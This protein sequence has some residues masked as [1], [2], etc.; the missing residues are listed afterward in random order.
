MEQ[1]FALLT[2][3]LQQQL[4]NIEQK[5]DTKTMSQLKS[6]QQKFLELE[7]SHNI[8]R[9]DYEA[10][11]RNCSATYIEMGTLSLSKVK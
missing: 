6:L 7:N 2:S 9:K 4:V 1:Q 11:Q 10:L 3:Q 5:P 8:L